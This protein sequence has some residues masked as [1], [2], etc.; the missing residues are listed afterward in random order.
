VL[1]AQFRSY[2]LFFANFADF[3]AVFAVTSFESC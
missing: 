1:V 3:F 2:S